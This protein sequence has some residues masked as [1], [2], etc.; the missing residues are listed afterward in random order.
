MPRGVLVEP[1]A[2]AAPRII[3]AAKANIP[4]YPTCPTANAAMWLEDHVPVERSRYAYPKRVC[5][6]CLFLC[7]LAG[8]TTNSAAQASGI[9]ARLYRWVVFP[10]Q[11][12]KVQSVEWQQA[13][14]G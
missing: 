14:A 7:V 4:R 6:D 5:C 11:T 3:A 8:C 12:D 9:Y 10:A 1:N 13:K 2:M